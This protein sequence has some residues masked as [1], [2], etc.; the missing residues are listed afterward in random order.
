MGLLLGLLI[1]PGRSA[2]LPRPNRY[3]G[4]VYLIR[5]QGWGFSPGWRKLRDRLREAG[6]RADDISDLAAGGAVAELLADHQAGRLTGPIVFVGHSRGGRQSLAA[7][8]RLGRAGVAVDLVLTADVAFPPA[9]P[10][11]VQRA[12]NLYLTHTRLY[13][14]RPLRPVPGNEPIIENIDLGPA[15][16]KGLNHLN[17]TS[18]SALQDYLF[19]RIMEVVRASPGPAARALAGAQANGDVSR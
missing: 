12:V 18:N 3:P 15:G 2:E 6:A 10:G 14:A 13:P 11:G 17:I 19:A 7:A 9:V 5:G 8:E 4:R 1:G 16:A